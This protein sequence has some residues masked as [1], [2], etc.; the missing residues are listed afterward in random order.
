L[1]PKGK[2]FVW[3]SENLQNKESILGLLSFFRKE[4]KQSPVSPRDR[5]ILVF[6]NTSEV[7]GAENILKKGGWHIRVMGPPPEIRTGCDLV[8]EF[9]LY[10]RGFIFHEPHR[11]KPGKR[12]P[13]SLHSGIGCQP[14]G[15][16]TGKSG[17]RTPGPGHH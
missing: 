17:S 12:S 10:T 7:I 11:V 13:D 4:N 15:R 2:P 6:E 8:I 16:K 14:P 3:K 5:G 9:P 1:P